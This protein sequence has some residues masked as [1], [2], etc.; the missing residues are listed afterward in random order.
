MAIMSDAPGVPALVHT[1]LYIALNIVRL[2]FEVVVSVAKGVQTPCQMT[3]NVE[4]L[5]RRALYSTFTDDFYFIL[6]SH[7]FPLDIGLFDL[8]FTA[9]YSFVLRNHLQLGNRGTLSEFGIF[10]V[11]PS[12]PYLPLLSFMIDC[13]G[14]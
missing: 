10:L 5:P 13:L 8:A 14:L 1:S 4:P 12:L 6:L 9:L 3:S 7:S 11:D 2:V